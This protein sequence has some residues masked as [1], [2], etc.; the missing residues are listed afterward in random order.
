MPGVVANCT[1][2]APDN[3]KTSVKPTSLVVACADNGIGV[4][5]LSWASW[6]TTEATGTGSVWENDCAPNCAGGTIHHYPAS[7]MLTDVKTTVSGP[8][9]SQLNVKYQPIGPQGK[10]SDAF[11]LEVPLGPPVTC[12]A[13]DLRVTAVTDAGGGLGSDGDYVTF[14]N[15]SQHICSMDGYP[16]FD[17]L[18][19]SGKTILNA[20]RGCDGYQISCTTT[21][22]YVTLATA[23]GTAY[24]EFVWHDN[25][26]NGQTCPQSDSVVLTPPNAYDHLTVP[27]QIVPCGE[28]P[29]VGIGTVQ[30][31][32]PAT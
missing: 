8:V 14:A 11:T 10:T 15:E 7:V 25:P 30:S 13:Q 6:T 5:D 16:G 32:T 20:G 24:F 17:L 1:A 27:L 3:Y 9:F 23:G 21:P 26:V 22:T 2:P 31:G 4:E 12:S 18:N 29:A 28:P 19:A